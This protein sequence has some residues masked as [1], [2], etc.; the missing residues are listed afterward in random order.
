MIG[1]WAKAAIAPQA[2]YEELTTP[3]K[4]PRIFRPVDFACL[5]VDLDLF[6]ARAVDNQISFST[7]GFQGWLW[8]VTAYET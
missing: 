2:Q 8:G 4:A 6:A 5:E 3:G 7:V 1:Q